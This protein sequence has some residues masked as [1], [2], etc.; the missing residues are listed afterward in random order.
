[1]NRSDKAAWG[2]VGV[3][4]GICFVTMILPAILVAGGGYLLANGSYIAA[5]VVLAL[6]A[7][8]F[9]YW[10]YRRRGKWSRG[11]DD[12]QPRSQQQSREYAPRE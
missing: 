9:G 6:A 12:A 1:M 4:A 3:F 7:A 11:E 2:L 5:A 8:T 10:R